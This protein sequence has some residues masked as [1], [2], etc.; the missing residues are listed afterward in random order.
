MS[1]RV[2]CSLALF[3]TIIL[4]A[5]CV[6]PTSGPVTEPSQPGVTEEPEAENPIVMT[7]N[8]EELT[9]TPISVEVANRQP[10]DLKVTA[11]EEDGEGQPRERLYFH[12]Q[13]ESEDYPSEESFEIE[14]SATPME[15]ILKECEERLKECQNPEVAYFREGRFIIRLDSTEYFVASPY[16]F[17]VKGIDKFDNPISLS[18]SVDLPSGEEI[19]QDHGIIIYHED[20]NTFEQFSAEL[21]QEEGFYLVTNS[22]SIIRCCRAHG[23]CSSGPTCLKPE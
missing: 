7:F 12:L 15:T 22:D 6:P 17:S 14:V 1:K 8:L 19:S 13:I 10:L 18:I 2:V 21:V 5:A 4:L 23:R 3:L 11:R 9:T 16:A 20:D